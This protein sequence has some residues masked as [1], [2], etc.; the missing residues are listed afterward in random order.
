[1]TRFKRALVR[2]TGKTFVQVG[3]IVMAL[4]VLAIVIPQLPRFQTP[5]TT[6]LV[7]FFVVGLLL[8]SAGKGFDFWAEADQLEEKAERG[9]D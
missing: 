3:C 8:W 4:V 9:P 7:I 1:M 6:H 2:E 5:P